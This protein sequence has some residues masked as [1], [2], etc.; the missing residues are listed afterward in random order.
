MADGSI[1]RPSGYLIATYERNTGAGANCQIGSID[2]SNR[3]PVL[4]IC[5]STNGYILS[6][7]R[8]ST[9]WYARVTNGDTPVTNT[10]IT[11]KV[12][13]LYS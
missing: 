7:Y 2:D 13:W 11:I 1:R 12:Y 8:Y 5:T 10:D 4:A 9:F 6:I 3:I